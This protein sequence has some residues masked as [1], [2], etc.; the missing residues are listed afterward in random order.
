M[1]AKNRWL[2]LCS[3][4][5]FTGL[6][7]TLAADEIR[8][9]VASNF[10]VTMKSLADAFEAQSTHRLVIASGSTGKHFAQ[11]SHGAPFDLFFAAD[12][13]RPQLLEQQGLA[14]AGTRFTYALGTLTLWQPAKN[15][16]H[17]DESDPPQDSTLLET[18][19]QAKFSY[20]AIANPK[21]APYGMA[22]KESLQALGL[23]E[24][25][26]AQVVRGENIAQAY[27]FVHSGNAQLGFVAHAQIVQ[28]APNASGRYWQVPQSYHQ[29]IE[30]QAVQLNDKSATREFVKYLQT[31]AAKLII[32]QHG[33]LTSDNL[34]R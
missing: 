32:Q 3:L 17:T 19:K 29:A 10:V 8:V 20:I 16:L 34:R 22:A 12:A 7:G 14:V 13:K 28:H 23:W 27:H 21:L 5:I 1:I 24:K 9:A 4:L 33:Y 25:L 11:I 2:T 30:Q 15:I 26:Q 6:P 18:L 31:P